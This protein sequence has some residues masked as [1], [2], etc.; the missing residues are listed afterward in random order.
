MKTKSNVQDLSK[1]AI[2]SFL[3]KNR[4][5][6]LSLAAGEAAYGIPLAY[7]YEAGTIYLTI[8]RKGRKLAYI[9]KNKKVSFAVFELPEGFGAPGKMNWTSVICD[10]VLENIT[11]PDAI[12]RAVRAGEKHMGMQAGAWDKLLEMV[13]KQP[14][15]SNFWKISNATYGG[16]GVEDEQIEFE[17]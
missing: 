15:D 14:G 12:T 8:S 1:D 13:L 6:V 2:E 5:G 7:F 9:D 11:D 3:K 4:V 16:R 17:A 10:G